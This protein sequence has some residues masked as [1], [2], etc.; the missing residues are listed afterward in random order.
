M[1]HTIYSQGNYRIVA[2]SDLDSTF[3]DLVGDCANTPEEIQ[4]YERLIEQ[5]GVYG[6]ELQYWNAAVGEGW[7][8]VDSCYGFIGLKDEDGNDHYIVDELKSQI[9]A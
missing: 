4:M 6:F 5:K 7:E 3:S 9:E 8:H 1:E 2:I